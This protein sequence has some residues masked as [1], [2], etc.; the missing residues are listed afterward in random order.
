M[1]KIIFLF[2]ILVISS[3]LFGNIV[4]NEIM[5]NPPESGTDTNEY[6]ELYNSGTSLVSLSN[7]YF[8]QGVTFI[9]PADTLISTNGYIILCE[10]TSSLWAVYSNML[11][12]ADAVFEWSGALGNS[13]ED[14]DLRDAESNQIDY[15][16]YKSSS[17]WPTEPNGNGPSLE[18]VD[19]NA[20][21][22]NP[23]FWQP[24]TNGPPGGT[25]GIQNSRYGE[26]LPAKI[27]INEIMYHPQ[28]NDLFEYIELYNDGDSE[29]DLLGYYFSAGIDY[30]QLN[31]RVIA[32]GAYAVIAMYTNILIHAYDSANI[33]TF[34]GEFTSNK[35]G[36]N[37]YNGLRNSGELIELRDS[38]GK[39][40]DSVHY[41]DA[42]P[43]PT[44]ADG[45]GNSLELRLPNLDNTDPY[46]WLASEGSGTP[47]WINSVYGNSPAERDYVLVE[48]DTYV[49]AFESNKT[50]SS[51]RYLQI[52]S[53][54]MFSE[55]GGTSYAS[56]TW[57]KFDP[58]N[59]KDYYD[60]TFGENSWDVENIELIVNESEYAT[61]TKPGL[62]DI[63]YLPDDSWSGAS[64]T[65]SNKGAYITNQQLAASFN[66]VGTI[67]A[68]T[69]QLSMLIT[70]LVNDVETGSDI[71]FRLFAP[72]S[73]TFI[74]LF[75]RY[76]NDSAARLKVDATPEPALFLFWIFNFGFW[77]FVRHAKA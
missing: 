55:T 71:S 29:V 3:S 69:I 72:N 51:K 63:Y 52:E 27:V 22:S 9:F 33:A 18:L 14:L 74:S 38:G 12:N 28:D 44:K 36:T 40:V 37:G 62:V 50:H 61:Y 2:G 7:W 58:K 30:T 66:G 11:V 21:N 8:A 32:T 54:D 6:F 70:Q 59:I 60:T 76:D 23:V 20:D 39:S 16:D 73:N 15:V 68:Q 19:P 5:Y 17:P 56:R 77:I 13:G 34:I 35:W 26:S 1:K 41:D 64:L 4:I 46:S 24:S 47:G 48:D 75:S 65:W 57:L 25:P 10:N 31:S 49:I 67:T 53:D 43:W 45:D 42:F